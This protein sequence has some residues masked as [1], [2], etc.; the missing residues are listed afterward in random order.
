MTGW[1]KGTSSPFSQGIAQTQTQLNLL[2]D[3]V[4]LEVTVVETVVE[5]FCM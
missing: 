5:V 3:V 2:P 4:A 1:G